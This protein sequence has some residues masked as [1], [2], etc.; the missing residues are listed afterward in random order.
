MKLEKS[1][2]ILFVSDPQHDVLYKMSL[3]GK[4]PLSSRFIQINLETSPGGLLPLQI[5]PPS[6]LTIETKSDQ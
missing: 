6:L 5:K 3:S 4:I 2:K 1:T